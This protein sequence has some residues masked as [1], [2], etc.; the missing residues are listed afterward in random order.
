MDADQHMGALYP[1]SLTQKLTA[2]TENSPW[3]ADASTSPWGR[4]IIPTEMVSVLAEYSNREAGF[5]TKGPAV[6]LFAD[7]EIRMLNGPLF[8]GEDYLLRREVAAIAESKRT[9]SYWVRTRIFDKSGDTQVAEV[10]LNHAVVKNSF[11]NYDELR[12]ARE[13]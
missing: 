2:I 8:V 10:M 11:E 7:L 12:A 6:G 3:Y 5:P 4:A 13:A 1:F 9:E